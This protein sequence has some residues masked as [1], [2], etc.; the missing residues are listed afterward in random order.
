MKLLLASNNKHKLKELFN[1][2]KLNNLNDIEII[3]PDTLNSTLEVDE[4]GTTFEENSKLKADAFYNQFNI[5]TIADDS[6]LEIETLDN[7]PGVYSARFSGMHGNDKA[8]RIKVLSEL[9]ED[10]NRNAQFR[11][12]ICFYDG[13]EFVYFNGICKGSIAK[14]ENGI[15]GFGYDSIFIPNSYDITFAQMEEIDKNKISHR[16]NALIQFVN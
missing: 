6:G 16:A 1:I 9:G 2:L 5:P 4:T 15:N 11:T 13:V 8:N 10:K 7:K 14:E 12:V 3:T